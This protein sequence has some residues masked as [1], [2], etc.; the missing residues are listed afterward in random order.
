[1]RYKA[2]E[3]PSEARYSAF[4][5]LSHVSAWFFRNRF[6]FA[7][8]L[9]LKRIVARHSRVAQIAIAVL[10][11]FS[12]EAQ[13]RHLKLCA[14]SMSIITTVSGYAISSRSSTGLRHKRSASLFSLCAQFKQLL[15]LALSA[16]VVS[17]SHSF[18]VRE[19]LP[20]SIALASA[21]AAARPHKI[22]GTR[23][24]ATGQPH[25]LH[26]SL[27]QGKGPRSRPF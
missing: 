23:H 18:R 17:F 27:L 3:S 4:R 5:V 14:K 2:P 8:R 20:P 7:G 11:S 1:M 22:H 15:S 6:N 24:D 21:R 10:Y 13:S 25:I 19:P 12:A 16:K 9:R 26:S